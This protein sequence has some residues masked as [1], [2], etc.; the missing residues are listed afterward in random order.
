MILNVI[1]SVTFANCIDK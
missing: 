1:I